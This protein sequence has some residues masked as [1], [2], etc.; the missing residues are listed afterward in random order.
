MTKPTLLDRLPEELLCQIIGYLDHDGLCATSISEE[1]AIEHTRDPF[2]HIK[3][4][5]LMS[6]EWR[7]RV[8]P[9]L[10]AHLHLKLV[11]SDSTPLSD[12][13]LH[14]DIT[15]LLQ[16]CS[17]YNM[18]DKVRTILVSSAE[19]F[20]PE[21]QN[22]RMASIWLELFWKKILSTF[23]METLTII[24]PPPTLALL[25][26][27]STR[28]EDG[29]LFKIPYQR[30]DLR[31]HEKADVLAAAAFM[32]NPEPFVDTISGIGDDED[33][34]SVSILVD[35]KDVTYNQGS[36][37]NI[38]KTYH[39]FEKRPPC[40]FTHEL[41]PA[42]NLFVNIT[43]FSWIMV[44]PHYNHVVRMIDILTEATKRL[45][46]LE[47]QFVPTPGSTVL[48]DTD[49]ISRGDLRL[50]DCWGE[51][52]RGYHHIAEMLSTQQPMLHLGAT[53]IRE[54]RCLDCHHPA[55]KQELDE[56]FEEVA[57]DWK[58]FAD[59]EW[60]WDPNGEHVDQDDQYAETDDDEEDTDEE[61]DH[62][63]GD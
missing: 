49:L 14:L 8:F 18:A 5:S 2:P 29:W 30:L 55:M 36:S 39:Y 56:L 25:T 48:D 23:Y 3:N 47:V 40:I 37:L 62:D 44:F 59:D 12:D 63:E 46:R 10:F 41:T 33:P 24:A 60:H 9:M 15:K 7:A 20:N 45:R 26:R 11:N 32:A 35:W 34:T 6:K 54:F 1:P 16:F 13:F 42:F 52:S 51:V 61:N 38:Y 43:S 4:M 21:Q 19:I 22:R 28:D 27:A 57:L 53:I 58:T 17:D 50:N 31:R